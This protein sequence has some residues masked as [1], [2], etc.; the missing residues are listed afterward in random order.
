MM[1]LKICIWP[2]LLLGIIWGAAA[3]W[4]DG[5]AARWLAGTMAAGFAVGCLVLLARL[6]PFSRAV[7]LVSISLLLVA[8]WWNL[9]PPRNDRDWYP[10]VARLPRAAIEGSRMTIENLR[11]F[12][13]RTETDYTE[14]W[15]SRTYDLDKLRGVDMF[16]F[17]W[18]S[19]LIAHTI[20]SWDFGG[21]QHL[22]I[23]I[24]TRKEK[25]EFYSA[26]RGFFRQYELYYVVA[27]ERDVVRLRTNYRGEQAYLYRI[28]MSPEGAR[29]LL[30]DYLR[31]ANLLAGHPRWYNA[32]THN[33]TTMIRYHAKQV[34]EDRPWDWRIL[35]NGR[36]DQLGY[37]RGTIDTNLPFPELKRRSNIT[38]KAKAADSAPDF[39]VRIRY[40]LPG[41]EESSF[42]SRLLKK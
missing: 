8:V 16:L 19:T 30:I 42:S 20:T 6:R 34:A 5:P 27:D 35:A 40:G 38:E 3:L 1:F 9:I 4:F 15:E 31:E 33:C 14:R 13:Y 37:E 22:A 17:F 25:G 29:A 10:D 36:L 32:L 12:D 23:S 7:L 41:G 2:L 39:S 26:V 28:R 11:N 21:G 18:G 24:E